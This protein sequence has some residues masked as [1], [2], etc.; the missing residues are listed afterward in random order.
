VRGEASYSVAPASV[1]AALEVTDGVVRDVRIALGGVAP[2][3]WRATVAEAALRCAPATR[4]GIRDAANAELAAAQPLPG[5]AFMVP[6][7]R[8]TMI[9]TLL[10]LAEDETVTP[11]AVVVG[12]GA[13]AP[14]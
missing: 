14:L 1:A 9:T 10:E 4:A 13:P 6:L 12:A 5:N 7:V 11:A 3:P 2:K 8:N